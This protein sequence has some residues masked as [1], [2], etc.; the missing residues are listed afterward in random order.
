M[1]PGPHMQSG[2]RHEAGPGHTL[3][4]GERGPE[5]GSLGS[6]EGPRFWSAGSAAPVVL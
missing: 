5:A 4:K 1:L 2:P 3:W 6:S